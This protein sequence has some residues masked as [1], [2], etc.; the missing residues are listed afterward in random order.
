MAGAK[1]AHKDQHECQPSYTCYDHKMEEWESR[2]GHPYGRS[3]GHMIKGA[4][5]CDVITTIYGD[6]KRERERPQHEVEGGHWVETCGF[7]GWDQR[8]WEDIQH[9]REG[10]RWEMGERSSL[11]TVRSFCSKN[12]I[13]SIRDGTLGGSLACF[14]SRSNSTV[15]PSAVTCILDI[16]TPVHPCQHRVGLPV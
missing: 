6:L 8:A 7:K 3:W 14:S 16:Y 13:A 2:S 5:N 12:A 10:G 4:W 11:R 1:K 15:T 9:W